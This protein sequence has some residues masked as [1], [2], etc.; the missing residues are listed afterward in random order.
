MPRR[1]APPPIWITWTRMSSPMTMVSPGLRVS[2]STSAS[3]LFGQQRRAQRRV[4]IVEDL[5]ALPARDEDRGLEVR[6]ALLRRRAD[7]HD[8]EHLRVAGVGHA[9]P[10]G[11]LVGE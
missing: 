4:R 6:E 3:L 7:A 8:D 2:C 5:V 9:D 11:L 10:L 1:T